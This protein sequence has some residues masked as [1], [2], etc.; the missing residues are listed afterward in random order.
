MF[1]SGIGQDS[2]RI[3]ES[4]PNHPLLLGGITL[5]ADFSL[6]GNSDSDVVLHAITNAISGI[7]GRPV[8]GPVADEMCKAGITNSI[9]YLSEARSDLQALGYRITHVSVTLECRRPKLIAHF[10]AMRAKVSELLGLGQNDVAFTA[11]SGEGLTEF[12]KGEGVQ[13]FA[14]VSAVEKN[15]LE[16]FRLNSNQ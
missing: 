11:T 12:G 15:F 10:P 3:S 1:K 7:T 5:P 4:T 8:L 13:A 6:E 14:V 16:L 9:A 2:H